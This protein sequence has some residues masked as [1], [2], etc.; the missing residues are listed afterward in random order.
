MIAQATQTAWAGVGDLT[1][2]FDEFYRGNRAL[3]RD[4]MY[5]IETRTL[6][7]VMQWQH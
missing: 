5:N 4:D 2:T 6:W 3:N 7:T 1:V